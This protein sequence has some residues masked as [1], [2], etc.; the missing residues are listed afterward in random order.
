[1]LTCDLNNGFL[2]ICDTKRTAS[3]LYGNVNPFLLYFSWYW[4]LLSRKNIKEFI[5]SSRVLKLYIAAMWQ[6]DYYMLAKKRQQDKLSRQLKETKRNI[7]W[8]R[9]HKSADLVLQFAFSDQEMLVNV[10]HW[11]DVIS[12]C[13]LEWRHRLLS[14]RVTSSL[15]LRLWR[16]FPDL[17]KGALTNR[18][19]M[20][21]MCFWVC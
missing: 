11:S 6:I 2:W 8:K 9:W 17:R 20:Y 10:A 4:L 21:P 13:A 16:G 7:F 14:I 18:I 15:L 12:C 3:L 5:I 1:M 19:V